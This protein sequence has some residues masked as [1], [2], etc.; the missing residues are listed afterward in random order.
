MPKNPLPLSNLSNWYEMGRSRV[1]Q[2][3]LAYYDYRLEISNEYARTKT[4]KNL[5]LQ[6]SHHICHHLSGHKKIIIEAINKNKTKIEPHPKKHNDQN[7]WII[8]TIEQ[9]NQ[10][11]MPVTSKQ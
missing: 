6:T 10:N 9:N 7:Q 8:T 11:S 5:R 3:Y 4:N 1:N 2:K